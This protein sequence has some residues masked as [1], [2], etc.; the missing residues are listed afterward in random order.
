MHLLKWIQNIPDGEPTWKAGD[1][2]TN[3]QLIALSGL[4]LLVSLF[5]STLLSDYFHAEIPSYQAGDIARTDI[6]VP[7]DILIKD[8]DATRARQAEA[9]AKA[10][11]VY[12]LDPSVRDNAISRLSAAF[13]QCR[14]IIAAGALSKRTH[15]H[16]FRSLTPNV[17]SELR[18]TV[19]RLSIDPPLDDLLSFLVREDFSAALEGQL[20]ELMKQGF[21]AFVVADGSALVKNKPGIYSLDAVTG[22]TEAIPTARI[23][24]LEQARHELGLQLQQNSILPVSGKPYLRR[25]IA[26]LISPN[27]K[28]DVK[29]TK[30]RQDQ[31]ARNVDP[32][33]RQMKKGKVILRQ[34]DEIGQVHIV[35]LDA[36]RK[37]S[38]EGSNATQVAGRGIIIALF[39]LIFAFFLRF[40]PLGQWSYPRLAVFCLLTLVVNILLL[41]ALW[42]IC[43]SVS[44]DFLAAPF[45]DKAYFLYVLPFAYGAMLV[46]IL[47]SEQSAALF[48][49]F[50]SLLAGQ[51]V[52]VTFHEYSYILISSLIGIILIRKA[53]Q[54]V[55]IIGAGFKLGLAAIAIFFLLQISKPEPFDLTSVSFGAVLAFLSGPL[56]AI[57]LTFSLPLC[58]RLF[59]V[60][61][62][63]R[64]SEL[65]NL[66]LPL[67]REIILKAPGTYN[68]SIAVG[69]LCEG[70]AKAIGLNPLFLRVA[71]LYH[72]IGKTL[73]PEYFVENQQHLNPHDQI[74]PEESVDILKGH[75]IDGIRLA[76][77]A[78]LPPAI[79]DL[80]PQHHGTRLMRFFYERARKQAE[81]SGGEVQEGAFR[82]PGPKPQ[83]KAACIL[84]L[85][86]SI[87]A[88][89][90]TLNDHSRDKLLGLIQKLIVDAKGDGQFSESDITLAEID[91]IAF[92]FLET[93][94]SY[95]HSR[96]VYPGFDFNP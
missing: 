77:Q 9:R 91:C 76:R 84:M 47:A 86:D 85:A 37:I 33:L 18:T 34:G 59:M 92:S 94:A 55:G 15:K 53:S 96:I 60:T 68:H 87:E 7:R 48:I 11:P 75:V 10:L 20:I 61:T 8:E 83:T 21:P 72:D 3:R 42:F 79:V 89:A 4:L 12:R 57:F 39:I 67:I 90:R 62:E 58:E 29:M 13:S 19:Q 23:F 69:T 27:L 74:G 17:R 22:K 63:I 51:S 38:Q 46:T 44:Q 36:L 40:V 5:L 43:A 45:N 80:I 28:L 66:N 14:K 35:Q 65:G 25:M 73:R 56:N 16:T 1:K 26:G 2:I 71:S 41:K 49:I 81:A 78:K 88:A 52:E 24:T 6:V 95:Y 32:V 70:A 93:L 31:D 64:L 82:Y 30:D 50:C 54:R